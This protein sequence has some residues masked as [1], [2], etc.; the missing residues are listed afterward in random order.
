MIT[1]N[2][3]LT[4]LTFLAVFFGVFGF[5]LLV[6][7]VLERSRKR[8]LKELESEMLA[9]QK[10]RARDTVQAFN[11]ASLGKLVQEAEMD[12]LNERQT[13][14]ER[15][16][17]MCDRADLHCSPV[18]LFASGAAI[19]A[20]GAAVVYILTRNVAYAVGIAIPISMLPFLYV[21]YRQHKRTEML[22]SQLPD[23][24]ELMSRVLR[25]GQ[26]ITQAMK[27][28]STEFHAPIASEFALCYEQQN[29]GLSAEMALRDLS[30]R[31]RILEIQIFVMALMVHRQTGGNLTELLDRL[32]DLI[33]KRYRMR[34]KIRSLTAEGRL[35][36][37]ILLALPVFMYILLLVISREYALEL[38]NHPGLIA[39]ALVMMGLGALWIRKI[40][41]FDF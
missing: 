39:G 4:G 29:L 1:T 9:R 17:A 34:G 8:R 28:I 10:V 12:Q 41:N 30:R 21:A 25:A 37:V 5:N 2:T 19:S 24:L 23:S 15:L 38:L 3:I 31:T 7:D 13:M 20:T 6:S 18:I 36:A 11:S 27:V 14:A 22:R 33:R 26:T 40:V 35:Q 16:E 32:A